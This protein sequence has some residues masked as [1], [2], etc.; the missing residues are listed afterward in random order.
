MELYLLLPWKR[1]LLTSTQHFPLFVSKKG[2]KNRTRT[3]FKSGRTPRAHLF[4]EKLIQLLKD[5]VLK[6]VVLCGVRGGGG[7]EGGG[8]PPPEREA[9]PEGLDVPKNR[10][11]TV[12]S[13]P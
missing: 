5:V 9:P 11:V 2:V 12:G 8:E 10:N 4:K 7:G 3:L 6:E 1:A 13:P